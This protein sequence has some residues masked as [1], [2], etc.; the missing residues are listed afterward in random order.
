M[1]Y[2]AAILTALAVGIIPVYATPLQ[3]K[4]R[5][6]ENQA[7]PVPI[8]NSQTATGPTTKYSANA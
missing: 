8:P 5:A 4:A 6:A 3:I 7:S 1:K 2:N